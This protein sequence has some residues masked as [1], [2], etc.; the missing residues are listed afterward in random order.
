MAT[1][2]A[3]D[4][5]FG[6]D[7][8]RV[9]QTGEI[10]VS[11]DFM[12]SP[13]ATAELRQTARASLAYRKATQPLAQPSA[14]CVFQNPTAAD[15]VPQ[16]IPLS[17]GALV[18]RAGFKGRRIGGARVSETHANFIV[19]D[20]GATAAD[21]RALIGEARAAVRDRVAVTLRDEVDYLGTF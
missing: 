2:P 10:V 14:G 17:A 19:N 6:Y 7:T 21:V 11:A 5:G 15:G 16:D 18:D 8:S 4:M 3:R 20:G 9:K 12:S 13:G 1:V